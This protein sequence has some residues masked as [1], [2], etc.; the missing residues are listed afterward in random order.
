[1]LAQRRAVTA[2]WVTAANGPTGAARLPGSPPSLPNPR[3]GVAR[4][5]WLA[6]PEKGREDVAQLSMARVGLISPLWQMTAARDG[7][8]PAEIAKTLPKGK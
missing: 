3:G 5:A 8:H 7:S 6:H 4:G 1:M 2:H